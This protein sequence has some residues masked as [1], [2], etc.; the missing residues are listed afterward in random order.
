MIFQLPTAVTNQTRGNIGSFWSSDS[1]IQYEVSYIS[2]E[3]VSTE[4]SFSCIAP[5]VKTENGGM[6]CQLLQ[7]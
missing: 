1:C 3:N 2:A 5:T 7:L 6:I 4:M